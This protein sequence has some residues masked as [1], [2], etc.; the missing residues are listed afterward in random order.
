LKEGGRNE[1]FVNLL[2][3]FVLAAVALTLAGCG[4][5]PSLAVNCAGVAYLSDQSRMVSVQ[6]DGTAV[7]PVSDGI[8][9]ANFSFSPASPVAGED[10]TFTARAYIVGKDGSTPLQCH[11]GKGSS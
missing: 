10:V 5:I 9:Y 11:F 7:I 6:P 4:I 3:V 1:T 2:V 8:L